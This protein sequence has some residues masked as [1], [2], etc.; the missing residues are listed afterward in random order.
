MTD[1]RLGPKVLFGIL[2]LL[3]AVV[4]LAFWLMTRNP[5]IEKT[6][7]LRIGVE[8]NYR[9]FTYVENGELIGFDPDI[10]RAICRQLAVRCEI[11]PMPFDALIPALQGGKLDLITAGLGINEERQKTMTFSDTYYRSRSLFISTQQ[12][13][14]GTNEDTAEHL[15]LGAQKASLQA[16]VIRTR[17]VP[18]GAKLIEYEDYNELADAIRSGEVEAIFVDGLS[19]YQLLKQAQGNGLYIGGIAE[20]LNSDIVNAHI[21]ARK[22]DEALIQRVNKAMEQLKAAGIYQTI[23]LRYFSFMNY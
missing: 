4:S 19:G 7:F 21:A 14:A 13:A 18:K 6:T 8:E 3:I 2:A 15:V 1:A 5:N 20:G 23:S 12:Y 11:I 17:F 22:N 16:E 9:P 10:S